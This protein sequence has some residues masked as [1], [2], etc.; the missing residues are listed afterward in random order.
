MSSSVP[1]RSGHRAHHHAKGK[2]LDGTLA[3]GYP[4]WRRLILE[5]MELGAEGWIKSRR[6]AMG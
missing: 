6:R 5:F 3:K 4:A 1:S 2:R